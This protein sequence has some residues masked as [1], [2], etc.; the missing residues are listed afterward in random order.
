MTHGAWFV[1]HVNAARRMRPAQQ[2][3]AELSPSEQPDPEHLSHDAAQHKSSSLP[4][5]L[6]FSH[7]GSPPD[8]FTLQGGTATSQLVSSRRMLPVQQLWI[9]T[10]AF[11]FRFLVK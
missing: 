5:I 2:S 7:V 11:V 6:P 4:P 9:R 3:S 1:L 10:N 8:V